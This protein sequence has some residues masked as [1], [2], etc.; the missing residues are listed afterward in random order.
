M[1]ALPARSGVSGSPTRATGNAA[2]GQQ[3]DFI[4]ERLNGGGA[5]EAELAATRASLKADRG[6]QPIS[7]SVA[8]NALTLTLNPTN[9]DF[10]SATLGSGTINTRTVAAAISLVISSGS[11][12]GTTNGTLARLAVLALDNAGTVE[13]AVV[14]LSGGVNLDES[15]VI[16]TTAEG[17]AGAA[18]SA[19]VIYSQTARSNVP[20][21]LLG[22]I[23]L[24]Q[25]T[26]GTWATAPSA[27]I[28]SAEALGKWLSGYGQTVQNVGGSRALNT[29][30]T[31]T[32]G[33]TIVVYMTVNAGTASNTNVLL[34]GNIVLQANVGPAN[35]VP[36]SFAVRP[37]GTYRVDG[38]SGVAQ[39]WEL[40]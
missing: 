22:F 26:A 40:R 12:L 8:S 31:N 39:W 2:F 29:T 10:R 35:P 30:Y 37:G 20:Y 24:T 16:S 38:S 33:R 15:G 17:A 34:D 19:S 28:G 7:A 18:D 27:V 6:I 3:Y 1:T 23:E 21:R 36:Y 4:N 14:N 25:A 9:L 32:T 13:L 5:T 11:T